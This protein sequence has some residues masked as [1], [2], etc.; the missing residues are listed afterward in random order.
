MK[1]GWIRIRQGAGIG[2]SG[3]EVLWESGSCGGPG[4]RTQDFLT[5]DASEEMPFLFL[6]LS[7]LICILGFD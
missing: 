5:F 4:I 2:R 3:V 1:A 6:G 7:F